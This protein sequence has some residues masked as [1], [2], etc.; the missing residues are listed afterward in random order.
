MFS[1]Q[2]SWGS[3]CAETLVQ[4][5]KLKHKLQDPQESAIPLAPRVSVNATEIIEPVLFW[6][7][8]LFCFVVF[9]VAMIGK[10]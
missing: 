9:G 10:F 2:A 6:V 5:L 8:I 7:F 1:D 4:G 3:K